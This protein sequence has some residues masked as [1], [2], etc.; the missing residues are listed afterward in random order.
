M[1]ASIDYINSCIGATETLSGDRIIQLLSKMGLSAVVDS[2]G[3]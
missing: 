3:K 1:S 2:D